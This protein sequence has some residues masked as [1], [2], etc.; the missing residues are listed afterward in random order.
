[1]Q[2]SNHNFKALQ[3]ICE[4]EP[5]GRSSGHQLHQTNGRLPGAR[6]SPLRSEPRDRWNDD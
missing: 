4:I 3:H 2:Q 6:P 1:M 5:G